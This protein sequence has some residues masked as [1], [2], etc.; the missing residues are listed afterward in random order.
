VCEYHVCVCVCCMCVC[1]YL[2][3]ACVPCVCVCCMCPYAV[4]SMSVVREFRLGFR[5]QG[6]GFRVEV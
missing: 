3:S 4:C 1:V 5:V 2:P 6:L